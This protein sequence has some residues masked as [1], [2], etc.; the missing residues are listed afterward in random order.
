LLVA[1]VLAVF[2]APFACP[3]PDGLESV[4]A[5]LGFDVQGTSAIVHAPAPDYRLPGIHSA[6]GATALA[7]ALGTLVVLGLALA[8][9]RVLVRKS[10]KDLTKESKQEP[11]C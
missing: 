2:V 7:G 8:L 5:K 1:L 4:A 10:V 11:P 6:A 3:W 9:G